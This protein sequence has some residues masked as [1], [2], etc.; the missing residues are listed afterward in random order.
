MPLFHG[1]FNDLPL[2]KIIHQ[3]VLWLVNKELKKIA[4]GSSHKLIEGTITSFSCRDHENSEN[5]QWG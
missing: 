3:N 2:A 1:L 4:K 5:C